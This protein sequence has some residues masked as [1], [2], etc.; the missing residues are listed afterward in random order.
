MSFSGLTPF[1]HIIKYLNTLQMKKLIIMSGEEYESFFEKIK[2][3]FRD[4]LHKSKDNLSNTP[5]E[6][7]LS[8]KD[9]AQ[10]LNISLPTLSKHIK[11]GKIP[12]YRIGN[13]VLLKLSDLASIESIKVK[14]FK[15]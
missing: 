12:A 2:N 1:N 13:R 7:Y 9:A 15:K 14:P 11:E 6:K 10:V 3:V 4:E 5:K 8:R